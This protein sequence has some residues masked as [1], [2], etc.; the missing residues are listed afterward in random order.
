MGCYVVYMLLCCGL[1]VVLGH[2]PRLQAVAKKLMASSL[3]SGASRD[4]IHAEDEPSD[5]GVIEARVIERLRAANKRILRNKE[6]HVEDKDGLVKCLYNVDTALAERSSGFGYND[7]SSDKSLRMFYDYLCDKRTYLGCKDVLFEGGL[8]V[9]LTGVV[10]RR[11]LAEDFLLYL[12]NNHNILSCCFCAKGSAISREARL[13]CWLAQ[14][15][16]GLTTTALIDSILVMIGVPLSLKILLR[17]FV[18]M[19]AILWLTRLL[20]ILF[21][22]TNRQRLLTLVLIAVLVSSSCVLLFFAAVL[23]PPDVDTIDLVLDYLLQ[24]HLFSFII[25]IWA[26]LP[27]FSRTHHFSIN[28]GALCFLQ[29]GRLMCEVAVRDGL[30][31]GIDYRHRRLRLFWLRLQ[32]DCISPL[33]LATRKISVR[34]RHRSAEGVRGSGSTHRASTIQMTT[35]PLLI[36]KSQQEQRRAGSAE[37]ETAQ[38]PEP[39]AEEAGGQ[40]EFSPSSATY[41]NR[42]S[43]LFAGPVLAGASRWKNAGATTGSRGG[44]AARSSFKNTFYFFQARALGITNA[45]SVDDVDVAELRAAAGDR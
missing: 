18:V 24:V 15:S 19:P 20:S 30:V 11:G 39:R 6:S 34:I 33:S 17:L 10:L 36:L 42:R 5:D 29:T 45:G 1:L 28:V 7:D 2:V 35:N 21:S 26:A 12:M 37:R 3:E 38:R 41:G 22:L 23:T 44:M 13:S 25:E 31:S 8:R 40:Q 32:V 43:G 16:A 4:V 9:P 14:H 27:L